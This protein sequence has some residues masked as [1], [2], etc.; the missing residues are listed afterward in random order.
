MKD[1]K[2]LQRAKIILTFMRSDGAQQFPTSRLG[3][4]IDNAAPSCVS[5]AMLILKSRDLVE[6]CGRSIWTLTALGQ[7][8]AYTV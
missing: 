3:N 2:A 4:Q 8:A 1:S 5:E 6:K 7:N